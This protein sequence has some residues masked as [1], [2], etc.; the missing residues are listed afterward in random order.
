MGALVFLITALLNR[1]PSILYRQASFSTTYFGKLSMSANDKVFFMDPFG[2]RQ[3]NDPSYTGTQVHH[4]PTAFTDFV[5]AAHAGG[6]GVP[7]VEGYAPFCKHIFVE[8]FCGVKCGYTKITDENRHLI[9]SGYEARK[10]GELPVLVQWID[11]KD[12]PAPE[13]THLDV[14]LY[15]REQIIA[16]NEAM[17]DE[18]VAKDT[19]SPWGIISIKG[20]LTDFELPMQPITMMRNALGKEEG[21][22]GVP[23]EK[24]KYQASYDF[25]KDHVPIKLT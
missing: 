25:W 12:C 7:L 10:E 15:S 3:F 13:A 4:N 2:L 20:Q 16:E 8:N 24:A 18:G 11:A 14:I 5:E 19:T 22:S 17:G 6:K 9:K 23:L 1:S 21:G